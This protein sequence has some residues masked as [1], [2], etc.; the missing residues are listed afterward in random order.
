MSA[1]WAERLTPEPFRDFLPYVSLSALKVIH[2]RHVLAQAVRVV[3]H[4]GSTATVTRLA[5]ELASSVAGARLG[6]QV[7]HAPVG[8]LSTSQLSPDSRAAIGA[9]VLSLYFHQLFAQTTWFL[10][11]RPRHFAWDD[12]TQTLSFYPTSLWYEPDPEF[13]RRVQSLYTGFYRGDRAALE[14]G[15]EL[16]DWE[17]R[18]D[19][20]FRERLEILLREHFGRADSGQM[21]F[22]INHFRATFD[23]IFQEAAR[24]GAKLHPGLTFLGV[25]LVGLYLTLESLQVPLDP[26]A[27]FETS[28]PFRTGP[29]AA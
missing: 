19:K 20:A 9:R 8:P 10:D 18:A 26:S 15:V 24:S 12:V 28:A 4:S 25:G 3:Q 11:L 27:A 22:H 5:S 7:S 16:Y 1:D 14:A 13:R 2:P 6:V 21:R 29:R 23:G 17:S